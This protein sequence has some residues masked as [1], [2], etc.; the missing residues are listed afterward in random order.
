LDVIAIEQPVE[1]LAHATF[2][3]LRFDQAL[4]ALEQPLDL[5]Q[6]D[7]QH[8]KLRRSRPSE[9][10]DNQFAHLHDVASPMETNAGRLTWFRIAAAYWRHKKK[11]PGLSP[12]FSQRLA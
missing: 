6:L 2:I 1:T 5:V 4:L 11:K 10:S 8:M 9:E 12:A 7:R 3:A